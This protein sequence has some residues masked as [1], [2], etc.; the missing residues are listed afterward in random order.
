MDAQKW[1]TTE[2]KKIKLRHTI[3][4]FL[5]WNSF[6]F[7]V[8]ASYRAWLFLAIE[9]A[10]FC[11]CCCCCQYVKLIDQCPSYLY[12]ICLLSTALYLLANIFI[13]LR[14]IRLSTKELKM[15]IILIVTRHKINQTEVFKTIHI[16]RIIRLLQ[17]TVDCANS[18]I[19]SVFSWCREYW[20][21]IGNF[22]S[23]AV[24]G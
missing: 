8:A 12:R 19:F 24:V 9:I 18:K 17:V 4:Y 20:T 16:A 13:N 22:E 1:Y 11:C 6:S 14:L 15:D 10:L 21:L 23:G 5:F 3:A 2:F 7:E